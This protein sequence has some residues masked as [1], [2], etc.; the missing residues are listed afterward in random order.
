MKYFNHCGVCTCLCPCQLVEH[1]EDV[2]LFEDIITIKNA[3]EFGM[4]RFETSLRLLDD[5]GTDDSKNTFHQGGTLHV[6]YSTYSSTV[7]GTRANSTRQNRGYQ[8]GSPE[9]TE[10]WAI[11]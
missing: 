6:V 8:L 9:P 10:A 1:S 3:Y 5:G 11:G 4:N 7:K 2:A